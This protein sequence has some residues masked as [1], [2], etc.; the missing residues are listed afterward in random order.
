ML[1]AFMGRVETP[2]CDLEARVTKEKTTIAT[3]EYQVFMDEKED[4]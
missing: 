2:L 3:L 1:G 4:E